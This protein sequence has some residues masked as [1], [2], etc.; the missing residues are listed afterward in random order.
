MTGRPACAAVIPADLGADQRR[1]LD[2][3]HI[4]DSA[5]GAVA[6]LALF[7]LF[8][9]DNGGANAADLADPGFIRQRLKWQDVDRRPF[10]QQFAGS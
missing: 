9:A 8:N 6:F 2:V 7:D 4:L 3:G 10:A 1:H 5:H